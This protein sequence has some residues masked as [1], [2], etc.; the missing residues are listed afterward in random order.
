MTDYHEKVDCPFCGIGG[1]V[2]D[3]TDIIVNIAH[4][5]YCLEEISSSKYRKIK[6]NSRGVLCG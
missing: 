3:H 5:T 2:Q 6:E 4:C 1:I